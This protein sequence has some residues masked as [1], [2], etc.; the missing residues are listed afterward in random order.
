MSYVSPE[1]VVEN[2]IKAGQAKAKLP[3]NRVSK[4]RNESL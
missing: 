3:V 4:Y 1:D 2:M